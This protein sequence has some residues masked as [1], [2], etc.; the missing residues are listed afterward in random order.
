MARGGRVPVVGTEHY[1]A[2][3]HRHR[4]AAALVGFPGSQVLAELVPEPTNSHDR[5]AIGVFIG[6]DRVG[7]I[8]QGRTKY[9]RGALERCVAAGRVPTC[10]AAFIVGGSL[11]RG[12][13]GV[14]LDV[15]LDRG[16]KRT[17]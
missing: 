15:A 13:V 10:A 7:Y 5:D 14:D 6:G 17:R 4:R 3:L 9:L 12:Q 8:A 16:T 2:A 11:P 1:Q